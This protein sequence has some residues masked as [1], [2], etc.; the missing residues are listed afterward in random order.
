MPFSEE[1]SPS[2]VLDAQAP[3]AAAGGGELDSTPAP[4]ADANSGASDDEL[5]LL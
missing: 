4:A 3:D 1:A 5:R 2:A